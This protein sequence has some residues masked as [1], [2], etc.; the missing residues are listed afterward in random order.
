MSLEADSLSTNFLEVLIRT[1][2]RK[3]IDLRTGKLIVK[4]IPEQRIQSHNPHKVEAIK[5]PQG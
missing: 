5:V 4:E 2:A 3:R 1:G